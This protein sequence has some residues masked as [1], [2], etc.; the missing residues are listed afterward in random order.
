MDAPHKSYSTPMQENRK[1][2][3]NG[4]KRNSKIKNSGTTQKVKDKKK[5]STE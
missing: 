2:Q 3:K 4:E 1:Y 5:E